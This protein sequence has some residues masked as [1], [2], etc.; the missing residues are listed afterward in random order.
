MISAA[1]I[2]YFT[3][4]TP[5]HLNAIALNS[6]Y[7]KTNIRSARF[8]GLTNGGQFCYTTTFYDDVQDEEL[9]GKVFVSY[10]PASDRASLDF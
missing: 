1:N 8:L 4:L 6:G 7:K 2:Q 9:T 10:D 3:T 5:K